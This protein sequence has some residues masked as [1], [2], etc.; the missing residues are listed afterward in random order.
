MRVI[1][2]LKKLSRIVPV[3]ALETQKM[4]RDY[5][6]MMCHEI[7]TPLNAVVGL[8][9]IIGSLKQD[10][11]KQKQCMTML[12]DSTKMLITLLDELLASFQINEQEM[13]LEPVAFDLT[14]VLE[15]AKHIITTKAEEKGLHL[16]SSIG[17]GVP[18]Y[19]M[20]DPLRI[21]QIILN[22]LGNAIKFT[23]TGII[24]IY[25]TEKALPNGYSSVS[26]TVADCGIGIAK[27]NLAK[28]FDKYTQANAGIGEKYGGSGLGLFISQQLAALMKG[29][30]TAKSWSGLGSHFTLTLPLQKVT[31]L[32]D[33]PVP[34]KDVQQ[35]KMFHAAYL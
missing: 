31:P 5:V 17:V 8:S 20:G 19:F 9:R 13:K 11:E 24:S 16:H 12:N 22:L 25:K 27:E 35:K 32:N 10:P 1:N 23:P 30:I 15:E 21:R 7:R 4:D 33:T 14:K 3:E 29:E 6:A 18:A 34:E 28:I 26:I 2:S